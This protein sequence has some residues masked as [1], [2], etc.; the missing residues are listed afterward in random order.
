MNLLR[1]FA[2]SK[3]RCKVLSTYQP[4]WQVALVDFIVAAGF[5]CGT[6]WAI[7]KYEEHLHPTWTVYPI[8]TDIEGLA[9]VGAISLITAGIG[10]FGSIM[11]QRQFH[12]RERSTKV[13]FWATLVG[14]LAPGLLMTLIL[15]IVYGFEFVGMLYWVTTFAPVTAALGYRCF[16]FVLTAGGKEMLKGNR[17]EGNAMINATLTGMAPEGTVVRF[18]PDDKSK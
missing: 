1:R 13:T 9:F 15:S 11:L 10:A 2:G 4:A 18:F 5:I 6:A 8:Y 3:F 7:A 17:S 16:G 12:V 14:A